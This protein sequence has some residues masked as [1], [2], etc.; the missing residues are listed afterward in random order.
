MPLAHP[1]S[2][3]KLHR[4][5]GNEK[6]KVQRFRPYELK[7]AEP[8]VVKSQRNFQRFFSGRP[9]E[10]GVDRTNKHIHYL[11]FQGVPVFLILISY[12]GQN[13]FP[14]ILYYYLLSLYIIL[15]DM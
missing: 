11:R 12:F 10:R 4:L 7:S 8:H 14:V 15:S 2:T 6:L 9:T 1:N 13:D 3:E 5:Q